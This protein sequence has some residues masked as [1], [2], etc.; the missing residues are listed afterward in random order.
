ISV[1]EIFKA[2]KNN[3]V[4]GVV[5]DQRGPRKGIKVKYFSKDTYTFSGTAAI[6]LKTKSPVLVMLIV[7]N[8]IGNYETKIEEIQL[9]ELVGSKEEQI[10]QFN[11]KYMSILEKYVKQYPEQWFWMHNIWK[12]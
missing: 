1:K 5:G 6:A 3:E 9:E 11:Q 7:R 12:Y 8:S 2:L 10:V 4:V